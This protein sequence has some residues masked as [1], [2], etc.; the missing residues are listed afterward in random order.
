[1][2]EYRITIFCFSLCF[3]LILLYER[4]FFRSRIKNKSTQKVRYLF[5]SNFDFVLNLMIK[6]IP[7][8]GP[9][10]VYS[11]LEINGFYSNIFGNVDTHCEDTISKRTNVSSINKKQ[12]PYHHLKHCIILL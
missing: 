1:M 7:I 4:I 12:Q 3:H 11:N 6:M 10:I 9:I 2:N 8:S 5:T